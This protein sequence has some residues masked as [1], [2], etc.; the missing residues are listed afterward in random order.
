MDHENVRENRQ[1][2]SEVFQSV[3]KAVD[4]YALVEQEI[5]RI[6]STYRN[7]NY[8]RLLVI[9]FGKAAFE[10]VRAVSDFAGDILTSGIIITKYGHLR[11]ET[12]ASSIRCFE[13]AHPVPDE[14]GLAAT[15]KVIDALREADEK[16]LVVC[17]ISG[18]GSA[19]LAAP[20]DRIT[21]REK[22]QLT[23]ELLKAGAD[24]QELNTVRKHISRVKGGRLAEMAYPAGVLSLILSDVIG[25]RLDVIA[26]GPTSP[27]QTTYRDALD[28]IQ[29]Y[30]LREKIPSIIT[31]ILEEG[32]RLEIP[33]TPKAGNIIFNKVENVIIGSNIKAI[34][35]AAAEAERAG[36]QATILSTELQGEASEVAKW[37]ALKA[38]EVQRSVSR[39]PGKKICLIAGGETTVTVRGGGLGGRNMELALSF[40][41]AIKGVQ[42]VTLL[43]AGTDG[44]DG[45]TDAAGAIVDGMTVENAAKAGIMADRYLQNND[46]Y[47]FFKAIDGLFITGPT[48][49]NVMDIQIILIE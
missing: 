16:T 42:G 13:A 33:E 25:D 37:L 10:M 5:G 24:I 28:V 32:V 23:Q 18:G 38:Q 21:L 48:G 47:T 7:G 46:S 3:L 41:I 27:D 43:S 31:K 29:R 12:L 34:G 6:V 44:T 35:I 1:T 22:Q 49:T 39:S 40:A 8:Q 14:Y 9:S 17:L 26:S 19:L 45:P 30:K 15:E 36:Y 2:A 4:P 11:D 20:L